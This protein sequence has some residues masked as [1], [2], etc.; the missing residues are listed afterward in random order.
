MIT[1]VVQFALPALLTLEEAREVFRSTAPIYRG[2]PGLVRKVYVL[3]ET[4]AGR[5]AASTCG[6][7][8]RRPSAPSAPTGAGGSPPVTAR[9]RA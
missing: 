6:R 2:M 9:S 1:A 7:A 8:A 4:A 5:P 3:G